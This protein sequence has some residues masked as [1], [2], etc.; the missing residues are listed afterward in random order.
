MIRAPK[1]IRVESLTAQGMQPVEGTLP[2]T[3]IEGHRPFTLQVPQLVTSKLRITL[4]HDGKFR[5]GLT[6]LEVWGKAKLPLEQLPHPAG[7][8]AYNKMEPRN[9]LLRRQAI[10]I[11]SVEHPVQPLMALRTF[12]QHR[13]IAG[14][15][16]NRPM[17]RIGWKSISECR[18]S[19][20]VLSWPF[21]MTAVECNRRPIT[22]F[23]L[24]SRTRG[25]QSRALPAVLKNRP[26]INGT[27]PSSHP[28]PRA[29]YGYS[30]PTMKGPQ[31]CYRS[32]GME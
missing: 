29:K 21:M 20:D 23:R 18:P 5:S 30:S 17:K 11:D 22:R 15:V 10:T 6:E 8:L 16:M 25:N 19:F 27:Q 12:C 1:S 9:F 7:N 13:P 28:S 24:G 31:R 3:A 14:P 4:V 2:T 32:D 26:A